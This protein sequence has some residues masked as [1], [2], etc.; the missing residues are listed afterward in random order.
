[1][2][3]QV[4][5][6]EEA[7]VRSLFD[8]PLA[9]PVWNAGSARRQLIAAGWRI[10]QIRE[11]RMLGEICDIAA[12]IGYVRSLPWA[13]ADL[14]LSAALPRL[15]QLHEQSRRRAIPVVTHRFWIRAT[16]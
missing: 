9:E 16:T 10:E 13:Y 5:A 12:L 1:L 8:L 2:T 7:S 15:R 6:D 14:D 11:E 3:Q 4:G